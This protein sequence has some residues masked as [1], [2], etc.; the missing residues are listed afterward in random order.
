MTK[1]IVI[2]AG[3]AGIMSA[4]TASEQSKENEVILVEQNTEIGKKL[5]ITGGGRCNFSNDR[6]IEDFF[7]K[8]VTNRNFLYSAFYTFSNEDLKV[9]INKL[10]IKYKVENDQKLFIS[11]DKSI[12][13]INALNKKLLENN[14]KI[15]YNTKLKELIVEDN[16]KI[17][18]IITDKSEIKA[19]KVILACGGCSYQSTGSNGSVFSILKKY[20]HRITPL[21]P[22]LVPIRCKE[23]FIKN[24]QGISLKNIKVTSVLKNK[25]IVK[26]GDVIFTHFGIGGP[27]SLITSSY[28]NKFVEQSNYKSNINLILD[29]LPEYDEKELIHICKNIPTKTVFK[30][31]QGLLPKNFLKQIILYAEKIIGKEIFTDIQSANIKNKDLLILINLIKT[32]NLTV[33]SLLNID[34]AIVTSGGISV[35]DINPSTMESKKI[36][37]LYFAGE[38]IDLDAETGGYNLQIAFSTGYLAGAN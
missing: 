2:G 23:D 21:I 18:G 17:K 24:M 28:I 5:K 19:D 9:F 13:L 27:V 22:A 37:N 10:N 30:N 36:K 1:I 32:M 12:D 33:E 16:I 25:K 4:I 11:S 34:S 38:M 20:N 8:I 3:P 7:P 26:F 35:N 29:F 6:N 15:L 14:I 31:I